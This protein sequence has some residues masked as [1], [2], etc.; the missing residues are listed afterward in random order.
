MKIVP[1]PARLSLNDEKCRQRVVRFLDRVGQMD[2]VAVVAMKP[3]GSV[4]SSFHCGRSIF[5][6]IGALDY[7]KQRAHGEVE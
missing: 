6:L 2:A 4:A 3:G 1:M 7:L 5:T